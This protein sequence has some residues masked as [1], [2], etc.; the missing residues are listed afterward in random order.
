MNSRII[1]VDLKKS[2]KLN[3]KSLFFSLIAVA[4]LTGC[5]TATREIAQENSVEKSQDRPQAPQKFLYKHSEKFN[6]I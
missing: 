4:S 1:N 2:F 3:F 5:A 6:Q